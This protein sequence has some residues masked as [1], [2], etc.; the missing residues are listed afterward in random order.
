MV[1]SMSRKIP[2]ECR[3]HLCRRGSLIFS[4]CFEDEDLSFL[5]NIVNYTQD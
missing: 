4:D 2:E 5:R 3:S 1:V